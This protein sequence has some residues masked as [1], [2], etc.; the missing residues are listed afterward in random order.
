MLGLLLLP[1]R[2]LLVA[3][4][5]VGK[6][7]YHPHGHAVGGTTCLAT[8]PEPAV[9]AVLELEPVGDVE[10]RLAATIVEVGAKGIDAALLVVGVQARGPAVQDVRKF[11]HGLE[12][13]QP[14]EL[15]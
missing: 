3:G 14:A 10:R 11:L 15:R 1:E 9:F 6:G 7:A 8:G 4:M 12:A 2:F 5:D 13:Q